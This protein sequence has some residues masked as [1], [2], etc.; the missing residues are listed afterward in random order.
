V[1]QPEEQKEQP[2]D[3]AQKKTEAL[4]MVEKGGLEKN[5]LVWGADA[6]G[7]VNW[8]VVWCVY[9]RRTVPCLV[10]VVVES[11]GGTGPEGGGGGG[12]CIDREGV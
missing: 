11:G 7:V 8:C 4:E 2:E 6:V 3:S 9:V 5:V 12:W 1:Q 10:R